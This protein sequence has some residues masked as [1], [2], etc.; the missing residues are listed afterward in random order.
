LDRQVLGEYLHRDEWVRMRVEVD[1]AAFPHSGAAGNKEH[2][3]GDFSRQTTD[4]AS[5]LTAP[6]SLQQRIARDPTRTTP[7][8]NI[9]V[10]KARCGL[11]S[12]A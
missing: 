7:C 1:D 10:I 11:D 12:D 3:S 2:G 6:D 5:F 9:F 8:L 4:C